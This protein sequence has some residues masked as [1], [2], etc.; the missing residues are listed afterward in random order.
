MTS[1]TTKK[2][3]D[4]CIYTQDLKKK[5]GYKL[6]VKISVWTKCPRSSDPSFL[7]AASSGPRMAFRQTEREMYEEVSLNKMNSGDMP[8]GT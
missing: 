4:Y 7:E 8:L 2:S 3:K 1:M 6:H 5:D